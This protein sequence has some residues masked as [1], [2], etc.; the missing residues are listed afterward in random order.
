M[1]N[2]PKL[3][4]GL[5]SPS[6]AHSKQGAWTDRYSPLRASCVLRQGRAL[7]LGLVTIKLP[8]ELL[9]ES[10][11]CGKRS[12]KRWGT[13][14][15]PGEAGLPWGEENNFSWLRLHLTRHPRPAS[16]AANEVPLISSLIKCS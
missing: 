1:E 11:G 10:K 12:R 2:K 8:S 13:E 5:A 14:K 16:P 9:I 7:H 3:W 6:L 4:G 15:V